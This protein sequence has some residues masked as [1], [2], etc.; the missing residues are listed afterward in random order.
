METKKKTAVENL[1]ERFYN[2]KK[3]I[4][5]SPELRDILKKKDRKDDTDRS[6]EDRKKI[7]LPKKPDH[8]LD[9]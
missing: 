7:A 3:N 1:R 4:K 8:D 2:I 6:T 9:I 5:P